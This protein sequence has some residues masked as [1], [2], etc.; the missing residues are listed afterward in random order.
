MAKGKRRK[1]AQR[2]QARQ[3]AVKRK[4]ELRKTE[5][6]VKFT[7]FAAEAFAESSK[8]R[9]PHAKAY[10]EN[11]LRKALQRFDGSFECAEC[12]AYT[13]KKKK[14]RGKWAKPQKGQMASYEAAQDVWLCLTCGNAGCGRGTYRHGVIHADY[15]KGHLVSVNPYTLD[16][17]CYRCDEFLSFGRE[18]ES[19]LQQLGAQLAREVVADAVNAAV[20]GEEVCEL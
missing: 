12:N 18:R 9:C 17:W 13:K 8:R 20:Y 19:V 10:N 5:K 2:K 1:Q 6:N 4:E 3:Q 16:C 7:K 15:S 11:A 14:G